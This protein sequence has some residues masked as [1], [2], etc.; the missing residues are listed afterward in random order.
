MFSI[1]YFYLL[2]LI[3]AISIIHPRKYLNKSLMWISRIDA[4]VS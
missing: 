3:I 4:Q 1:Y 2:L